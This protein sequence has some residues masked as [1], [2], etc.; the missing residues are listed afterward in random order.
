MPALL[1]ADHDNV[2]LSEATRRA[3]RA[4]LEL[5]KPVDVLVLGDGC[6]S[7]AE[8]ASRLTGVRC[9]LLAEHQE[10]RFLPAEHVAATLTALMVDY[11]TVLGAATSSARNALPRVAAMLGVMQVSDVIAIDDARTFRRP[12]YAGNAIETV[13]CPAGKMVLTIRA[14]AFAAAD[15]AASACRVE[16]V[17]AS[18]ASRSIVVLEQSEANS[19][20][21]DLS[22]SRIV[23][24]GGRALGSKD[25]FEELLFPLA[26][27]L[28]AAVGASRAA[29]DA[30][31]A[32]NDLQVG[33]TG[34]IVAPSLY[35][36]IGISGAVQHL[37]GIGG[38][39]LVVAINSDADAP[40]FRHAN[41]GLVGDLFVLVPELTAALAPK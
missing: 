4:A 23:V 25:K 13:R 35:I 18:L 38:A 1:L 27:R 5:G 30:G 37:A 34:K 40:I 9:V 31:Y 28:S 14:S 21:P 29:V 11:E 6:A 36:A 32:G 17:T 3:L 33:Q 12:I 22:T 15:D 10:L 39:K 8:Q 19:N 41:Y 7:V 24:S 16:P 2:T 26:E 20:R